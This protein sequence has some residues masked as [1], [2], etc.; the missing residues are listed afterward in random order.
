MKK[1]TLGK[2]GIEVTELCFGALTVGPLQANVSVEAG[3]QLIRAALEEGINF[4][5]TAEMYETYPYIKKALEGYDDEVIIASKSNAETYEGMEKAIQDALKALGRDYVDIFLL[6]AAK[7]TPEVF[8][9]RAGALKCLKDYKKRG[10]LKAIGISTHVVEVV[11]RAAEVDDMDIVFPIINKPGMGIVGGSTED[12]ISAI[13]KCY[14]A[15]KGIYAMKVLAGGHLIGDNLIEAFDF[16]R[17]IEGISSVAVGMV[18]TNELAVNLKIFRGEKFTPKEISDL[19]S[20]KKMQVSVACIGCGVCVKTCPNNAMEVMG[21]KVE[22]DHEK[23]L[24]CGYCRPACPEFAL[25][26]V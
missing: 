17:R 4:I 16:V 20:S 14:K 11:G 12:M 6:H 3:A 21:E 15:G 19:K 18:T 2:T 26:L 13:Q 10:I 5:D 25:R 7:V 23:C 24:L 9:E 1:M 22:V 8:A